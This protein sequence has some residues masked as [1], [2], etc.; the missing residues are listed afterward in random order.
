[1]SAGVRFRLKTTV[2]GFKYKPYVKSGVTRSYATELTPVTSFGI[3]NY[4]YFNTD[5]ATGIAWTTTGL[6]NAEF[7]VEIT[8]VSA[9]A[10]VSIGYKT[11][12]NVGI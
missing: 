7:G 9:A 2:D 1:M 6:Q 5:P 10:E 11:L 12:L 3:T 8:A 4:Y